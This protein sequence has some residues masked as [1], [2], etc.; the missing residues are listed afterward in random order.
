MS[1]LPEKEKILK[2]EGYHYDFKRMTYYNRRTKKIFSHEAIE[3]N[4]SDWLIKRIQEKNLGS[5]WKFYFNKEPSDAIKQEV[6]KEF[7]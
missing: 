1:K 3:D 5:D 7:E 4:G 6:L 2:D